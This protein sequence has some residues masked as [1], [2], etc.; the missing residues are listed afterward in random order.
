MSLQE[1]LIPHYCLN[2][3]F[4]FNISLSFIL[5]IPGKYDIIHLNSYL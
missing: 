4:F 5:I 3:F 2:I 1:L